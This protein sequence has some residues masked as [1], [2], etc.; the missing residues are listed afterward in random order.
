MKAKTAVIINNFNHLSKIA[1]F[2]GTRNTLEAKVLCV[3]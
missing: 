3:L 2:C 1:V